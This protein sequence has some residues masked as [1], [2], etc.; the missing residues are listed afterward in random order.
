M[1]NQKK[2]G[3]QGE[4]DPLNIAALEQE[5]PEKRNPAQPYAQGGVLELERT[6]PAGQVLERRAARF[7]AVDGGRA[8]V[9]VIAKHGAFSCGAYWVDLSNGETEVLGLCVSWQTLQ[10]LR[11][12]SRAQGYR[13]TALRRQGRRARAPRAK[14]TDPRQ[15]SLF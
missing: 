15:G 5:M 1:S 12:T 14:K 4:R 9:E 7:R 8:W 11:E 6:S 2:A 13:V 10:R 3:P